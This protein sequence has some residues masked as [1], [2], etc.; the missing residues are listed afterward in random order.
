[1]THDGRH[2]EILVVDGHTTDVPLSSVHSGVASIRDIRP[3]LF[4]AKLNILD[5]W[6][7]DIGIE[8]LE[9]F[10]KENVH[11]VSVPKFEPL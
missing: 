9:A 1:M 11:V 8:H 3:V 10:T 7:T 2:K 4:L 5:S 6:R